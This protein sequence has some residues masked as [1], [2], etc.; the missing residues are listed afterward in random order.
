MFFYTTGN[1][2]DFVLIEE[3]RYDNASTLQFSRTG[4]RTVLSSI[5]VCPAG[6][7]ASGVE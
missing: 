1:I 7:L 2:R 6:A 5:L 4:R 3:T